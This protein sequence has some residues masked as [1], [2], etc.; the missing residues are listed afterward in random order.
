MRLLPIFC[1][2]SDTICYHIYTVALIAELLSFAMW[3]LA[4]QHT[5]SHTHTRPHTTQPHTHTASHTHGTH[6]RPHTHTAF[7]VHH[8]CIKF[9][10]FGC[11]ARLLQ[12]RSYFY[13]L[14]HMSTRVKTLSY[15]RALPQSAFDAIAPQREGVGVFAVFITLRLVCMRRIKCLGVRVF[16]SSF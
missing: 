8:I 14:L 15:H 4:G 9:F 5:V 7:P 6:T 2:H 3:R 10:A 1:L 11:S 12:A 13:T 16:I